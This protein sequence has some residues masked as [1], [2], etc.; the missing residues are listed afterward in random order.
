MAKT[1][2]FEDLRL[3]GDALRIGSGVLK[4]MINPGFFSRSS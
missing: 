4:G 1:F 3:V 2:K